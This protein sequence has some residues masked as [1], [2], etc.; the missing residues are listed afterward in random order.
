MSFSIDISKFVKKAGGNLD[1]LPRKVCIDLSTRVVRRTPV[2]TGR[3][4]ANWFAAIDTK[5]QGTTESTD[6]NGYSTINNAINQAERL[7]AG[8][9]YYLI[10]NLPYIEELEDGSSQQAPQGMVKVSIVEFK[11]IVDKVAREIK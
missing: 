7:K 4:R 1:Q 5:P 2:D 9:I 8:D 6:P 11:G 3:A 10:N